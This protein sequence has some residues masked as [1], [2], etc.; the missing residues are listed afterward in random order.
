MVDR[1]QTW[2]LQI[3]I[4]QKREKTQANFNNTPD[5]HFD[6]FTFM[7]FDKW[8]ITEIPINLA[9]TAMLKSHISMYVSII[10]ILYIS[11]RNP[12][13]SKSDRIKLLVMLKNEYVFANN[14]P[15][16][17]AEIQKTRH[18]FIPFLELFGMDGILPVDLTNIV[19]EYIL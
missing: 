8:W 5:L 3:K 9:Q 15:C 12:I 17:Y 16:L 11:I 19:I 2:V 14:T 10:N 4:I 18:I 13:V 1:Y 7:L 6:L